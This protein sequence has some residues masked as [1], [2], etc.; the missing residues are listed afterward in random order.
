MRPTHIIEDKSLYLTNTNVNFI[1]K[2]PHKNI[3][4]NVWP[5]S[6]HPMSQSSWH[7][8]WIIATSFNMC[9]SGPLSILQL[10]CNTQVAPWVAFNSCLIYSILSILQFGHNTEIASC[11]SSQIGSTR[12]VSHSFAAKLKK[13]DKKIEFNWPLL[14]HI[15]VW[16]LIRIQSTWKQ[17]P[18]LLIIYMLYILS[19][20]SDL[21]WLG[22]QFLCQEGSTPEIS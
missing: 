14:I 8:K 7:V 20:Y 11:I 2:C 15:V 19:K 9:T 21:A 18:C 6:E 12:Q 22:H 4:N 17:M 16:L 10:A 1:Q 3:Q 13:N 5:K